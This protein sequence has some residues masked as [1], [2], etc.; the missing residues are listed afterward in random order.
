MISHTPDALNLLLRTKNTRLGFNEE[1]EE[2]SEEKKSE[3]L[4]YMLT[5]I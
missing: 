4:E 5:T 3:H 2:W 1:P